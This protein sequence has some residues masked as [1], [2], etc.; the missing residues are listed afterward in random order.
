[1]QNWATP[2]EGLIQYLDC[3]AFKIEPN[4][5]VWAEV[6]DKPN[7][8]TISGK[9]TFPSR[10]PLLQSIHSLRDVG[11]RIK[12]MVQVQ[13][14]QTLNANHRS[15]KQR[16]RSLSLSEDDGVRS[17]RLSPINFL[18]FSE[19]LLSQLHGSPNDIRRHF[20]RRRQSVN[21]GF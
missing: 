16:L 4:G 2:I 9:H 14:Q 10:Q 20:Q 12:C 21:E 3:F 19:I 15:D 6:D 8:P 11:H 5:A 17:K 1:M 18:S 7:R 13:A